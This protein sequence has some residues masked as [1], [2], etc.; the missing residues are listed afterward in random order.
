[1]PWDQEWSVRLR[2]KSNTMA[3]LGQ[4][5]EP[6]SA[7]TSNDSRSEKAKKETS[8]SNP[9]SLPGAASILKGLFGK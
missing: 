8:D 9:L 3:M 2:V 1:V 5:I 7:S 4:E 6:S